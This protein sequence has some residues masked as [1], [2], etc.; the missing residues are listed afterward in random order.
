MH[1]PI[2]CLVLSLTLFKANLFV[3][4]KGRFCAFAWGVFAHVYDHSFVYF[5]QGVS[6]D[7]ADEST[8]SSRDPD[9]IHRASE[10]V[11]VR[12]AVSRCHLFTILS[13]KLW[14]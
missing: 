7:I 8:W 1:A 9:Q 14:D 5:E 10:F 4:Y 2:C 3:Q 6:E 13:L 12:Y 11:Q